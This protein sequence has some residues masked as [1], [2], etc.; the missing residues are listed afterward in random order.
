RY[1]GASHL[2]DGV[3]IVGVVT[4]LR[5]QVEGDREPGLATVEQIAKTLVRLLRRR[6]AGVLAD[7]PRPPAVHVLVRP[8]RKGERA[9]EL[10]LVRRVVRG[11]DRLD[12]DTGVGLA[13]VLGGRHVTIVEAA[14]SIHSCS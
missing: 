13:P 12:L 1:T 9:R 11:V 10:E 5:R 6:E 14:A 7:R 2:T 4:E 3:R 8:P